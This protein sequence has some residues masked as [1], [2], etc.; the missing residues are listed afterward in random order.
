MIP[1]LDQIRKRCASGTTPASTKLA[2]VPV[3]AVCRFTTNFLYAFDGMFDV[4]VVIAVEELCQLF[5]PFPVSVIRSS[6]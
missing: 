4:V 2:V 3:H 1:S 6:Y 5:A